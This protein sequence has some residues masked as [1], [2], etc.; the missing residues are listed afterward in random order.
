MKNKIFIVAT[1]LILYTSL[2]LAQSVAGGVGINQLVPDPSAVL[3]IVAE[4]QGVLLPRMHKST[5]LGITDPA[6]GLMAIDTSNNQVNLYI[7]RG[8]SDVP[9]WDNLTEDLNVA[10]LVYPDGG[11]L[12]D[13]NIQ[14]QVQF[15][16]AA[17]NDGDN[18]D[19]NNYWYL[20]PYDGVY[21]FNT[22]ITISDMDPASEWIVEIWVNDGFPRAMVSNITSPVDVGLQFTGSVSA[23]L[24]LTVGTTVYVVVT[25]KGSQPH[26]LSIDF[27][28]TWFS[29]HRLY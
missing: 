29:A 27:I 17:F 12:I 4:N 28:T 8:P 2:A 24:K 9:D 7:Q 13:L 19:F 15:V 21:Q 16:F 20:V 14:T 25:Q 11:Q 3:D 6:T 10:C 22:G 26:F 1:A 23:T 5:I 18:F